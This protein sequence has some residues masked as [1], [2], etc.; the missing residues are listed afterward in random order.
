MQVEK[1]IGR[2]RI[3]DRVLDTGGTEDLFAVTNI[4][5]GDAGAVDVTFD[6]VTVQTYH[7]LDVVTVEVQHG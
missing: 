1:K 2:L 5:N 6:G 3:G 7:F 4:R